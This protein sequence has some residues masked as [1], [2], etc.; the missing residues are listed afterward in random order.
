MDGSWLEDTRQELEEREEMLQFVLRK[1]IAKL[2]EL[3]A[4]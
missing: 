2:E 3:E 1:R 4:G